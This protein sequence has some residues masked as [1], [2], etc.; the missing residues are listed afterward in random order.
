[1]IKTFDLVEFEGGSGGRL[2]G[3]SEEL[4]KVGL[5]GEIEIVLFMKSAEEHVSDQADNLTTLEG[6]GLFFVLFENTN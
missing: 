6:Y 2:G 3:A 4:D 5:R 1:M